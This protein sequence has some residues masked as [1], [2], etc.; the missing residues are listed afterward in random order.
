M[1]Q[2]ECVTPTNTLPDM[3]DA[4]TAAMVIRRIPDEYS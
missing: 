4:A 2:R 3:I 1:S